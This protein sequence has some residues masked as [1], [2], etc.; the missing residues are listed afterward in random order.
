LHNHAA[1]LTRGLKRRLAEHGQSV[2]WMSRRLVS[3]AAYIAH[4]RVKLN[5]LQARLEHA[6]RTPLTRA[7]YQLQHLQTRLQN[8]L[9]DTRAARL[10]LNDRQRRIGNAVA[11][12][13]RRQRQLLAAQTAQLEL[14]NPQRTLERGYAIV[15]D[16]KGRVLRAPA[17]LQPRSNV[18]LRLAEGSAEVGIASVQPTLE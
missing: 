8:R 3:P 12:L 18:T 4:E 15:T 10:L 16:A 17:E 14:L 13:S 6:T 1:D 7:R 9:P 5:A 11:L 2:D